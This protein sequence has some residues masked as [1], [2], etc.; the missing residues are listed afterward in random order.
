MLYVNASLVLKLVILK[1]DVGLAERS[2]REGERRGGG[3]ER[4][5]R[6]SKILRLK[7]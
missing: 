1:S 5:R 6:K 4:E 2:Q 7:E 3:R